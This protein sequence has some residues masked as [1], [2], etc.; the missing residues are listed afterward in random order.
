MTAAGV[1]LVDVGRTPYRVA[2][3]TYRTG[4]DDDPAYVLYRAAVLKGLEYE[5]RLSG[6]FGRRNAVQGGEI[7]VA[8]S[9]GEYDNWID[10]LRQGDPVIIRDGT[11]DM[12]FA[13]FE[14]WEGR[15]VGVEQGGDSEIRIEL[16]GL[17]H[18][19]DEAVQQ[20]LEH[21]GTVIGDLRPVC[22][23]WPKNF[24]P[25]VV[26]PDTDPEYRV[27][28]RG[29]VEDPATARY[30]NQAAST[31][32]SITKHP[33]EHIRHIEFG[34]EPSGSVTVDAK[35][36]K[37]NGAWLEKGGE[38]LQ[39]LLT[40]EMPFTIGLARGGSSN[41]LIG[42]DWLSDQDDAY[43][44]LTLGHSVFSED[45]VAKLVQRET[46]LDYDGPTRTFTIDGV[47]NDTPEEND[48][49][50]LLD[51]PQQVGPL[52]DS[53]INTAAFGAWDTAQPHPIGFYADDG[54]KTYADALAEILGPYAWYAWIDQ[55]LSIGLVV[56]PATV[57]ADVEFDDAET[58]GVLQVEQAPPPARRLKVGYDKNHTVSRSG[59]SGDIS[60]TR[61]AWIREEFRYQGSNREDLQILDDYPDAREEVVDTLYTEGSAGATEAD[62]IWP[63]VKEQRFE[64]EITVRLK[65]IKLGQV[66]KITDPHKHFNDGRNVFVEGIRRDRPNRIMV[67]EAWA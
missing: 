65:P 6:I 41:T 36:V 42:P 38:G 31:S 17:G 61:E 53:Q 30:I 64:Y 50:E 58:L 25:V 48:G 63:L 66:A 11:M 46:V 33:T 51:V 59:S 49:M 12:A 9:R 27:N 23:G 24:S 20:V 15:I 2:T 47:W 67:L 57:T 4:P 21:T 54:R 16:D 60:P 8:S 40:R 55:K 19:L 13:D 43:N 29:P 7:V 44:G 14:T 10:D 39:Y 34:A 22:I 62:R 52:D 37:H 5:E 32:P 3:T 18:E 1:T 28:E 45:G 56:D 26:D 35:G